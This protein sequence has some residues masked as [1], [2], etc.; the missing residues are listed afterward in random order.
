MGILELNELA[1][2]FTYYLRCPKIAVM[3]AEENSEDET[4]KPNLNGRNGHHEK[5]AESKSDKRVSSNIEGK[6]TGGAIS[7]KGFYVS[8]KLT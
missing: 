1:W 2:K 5:V 3:R 4:D 8:S 6:F 7:K